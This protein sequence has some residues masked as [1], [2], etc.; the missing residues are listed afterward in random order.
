MEALTPR[1]ASRPLS[2]RTLF[3]PKPTIGTRMSED[4][5]IF[6]ALTNLMGSGAAV[7]EQSRL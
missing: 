4:D 3:Q 2:H 1:F 5:K 7:A 6:R